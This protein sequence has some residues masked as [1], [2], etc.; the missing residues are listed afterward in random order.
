MSACPSRSA[1]LLGQIAQQLRV[2]VEHFTRSQPGAQ[3]DAEGA[4]LLVAG[5]LRDP[6]G[7]RLAAAFLALPARYRPSLASVAESLGASVGADQPS[8]DPV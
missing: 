2:P 5:M 7:A 1:E 3:A 6:E 4:A 8:K